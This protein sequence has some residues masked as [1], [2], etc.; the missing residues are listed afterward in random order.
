MER[1]RFR[2]IPADML[3]ELHD[4]G[5]QSAR[6]RAQ[7][8]NFSMGGMAVEGHVPLRS[9]ET[10]FLKVNVPIEFLGKVVY[11]RSRGGRMN[12]GIR[13]QNIGFFDKLRL[14]RYVTA[15]FGR[16]IERE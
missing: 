2:R 15:K 10:L 11:M 14:R 4:V 13:F 1:R 12:Y 9:G 5:G 6:G 8:R 16:E 7:V 3:V